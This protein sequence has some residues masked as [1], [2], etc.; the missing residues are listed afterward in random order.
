MIM[1]SINVDEATTEC[2]ASPASA[3]CISKALLS[4]NLDSLCKALNA[5]QLLDCCIATAKTWGADNFTYQAYWPMHDSRTSFGNVSSRWLNIYEQRQYYNHDPRFLHCA[6]CAEP[7]RWAD[8]PLHKG[9]SGK[10]AK[11]IMNEASRHGLVDGISFPVHGVGTETAVFCLSSQSCL[12]NFTDLDLQMISIF[13]RELHKHVRRINRMKLNHNA[14]PIKLTKRENECMQWT[15]AGK[16]SW[17]ISK[18]ID[19]SET[20]VVFHI[21]NVARKLGATNR[22]E[23]VAKFV[24]R[25][26]LRTF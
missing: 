8:L 7:I 25:G 16:T 22:A 20:T 23:A 19:R 24:A 1:S 11:Q 6:S 12:P 21:R 26:Y 5:A 18:I 13:A 10:L 2:N 15:A 4:T 3:I 14:V 17:E 9:S